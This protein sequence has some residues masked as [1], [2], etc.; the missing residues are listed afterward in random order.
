MKTLHNP[1]VQLIAILLFG[2]SFTHCETPEPV[3]LPIIEI[4]NAKPGT[5]A[6]LPSN[7]DMSDTCVLDYLEWQES[8]ICRIESIEAY[9]SKTSVRAGDSIDVY[10]S[11]NPISQYTVAL[12]RMGYYGGN[13]G[14]LVAEYG[15]FQ[16]TIQETPEDG[17]NYL[18]ECKWDK[19]FSIPISEDWIS[20]V[21]LGKMTTQEGWENYFIFIVKDD[22]PADFV[23]QC[24]DITWQAYNR[25]PAW[26]SLYDYEVDWGHSPWYT[27][28]GPV[29]GFDRPYGVYLNHLP[30][31]LL[32][33][34][35]GSG[36]FLLWEFPLAFW[37]ESMG[38]DV[39]YISNLDTHNEPALLTR[40]K[41]FLSVGHDEYWSPTMFENVSHARDQGVNILFLSGNSVDGGI[42]I[43]PST[44]GIPSRTFGRTGEMENEEELMGNTSYGVGLAHWTVTNPTHWIFENTGM[45][46]GDSIHD[47]VG[48]EY[49]GYPIGN[50]KGIE[51]LAEGPLEGAD[52]TQRYA[53]TYYELAQGNFV[54]NAATCWWNMRLSSPPGH[55][56][57]LNPRGLYLD[58]VVDF[59][60]NDTRLQRI[61]QNLLDRIVHM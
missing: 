61:T 37:M 19:S 30:S 4:E 11:T 26:R 34:S 47:L 24:S 21:Y 38:Y 25:W 5:T 27:D 10:V 17:E 59:R 22:R 60:E 16:G 39:T 1:S 56:Y 13:G 50:Q 36:E 51:V 44:N 45:E 41:G 33:I 6:W 42:E 55:P 48:W 43:G 54:F 57:P 46:A 49:H 14:R 2:L 18:I 8:G 52:S 3:D 32:P 20:G 40:G 28:I 58:R 53:A 31:P 7:V 12:Y 29:V 15:P 35:S 9:C 23:F